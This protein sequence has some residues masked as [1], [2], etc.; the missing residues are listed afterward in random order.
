VAVDDCMTYSIGFRAPTW[1]EL[2]EQFLVHLQDRLSPTGRFADP[3]LKPLAQPA[4]IAEAMMKRVDAALGRIR[5]TKHDVARFLG[6]YLTEP[7]PH[8]FF[9]PP[10]RGS[11]RAFEASAR[12]HGVSLALRTEMLYRGTRF[13]INGE[14]LEAHGAL[15]RSLREL[16]D[17]RALSLPSGDNRELVQRLHDWYRAGYLVVGPPEE[18]R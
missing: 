14:C 4:R 13:F 5:W 7:K 16:A 9:R 3:D 2:T 17:R 18:T 1:H 8:V 10:P 11:L 15:A 12:R 6:C